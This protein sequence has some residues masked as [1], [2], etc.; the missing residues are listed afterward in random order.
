MSNYVRYNGESLN[1]PSPKLFG[2]MSKVLH[3]EIMGRCIVVY[4]HFGSLGQLSAGTAGVS[5]SGKYASYVNTGV[6]I[7][8]YS[9]VADIGTG[10]TG[11]LGVLEIAGND[12]DNDQGFVQ[13]G[14]GAGAFRIDNAS[15]NTGKVAFEAR[16]L[17]ESIAN[18]GVAFFL[19]L[20]TGPLAD[21]DLV[22]DTGAL[23]AG[24]GYIG[25]RRLCDDGDQMDIVYQAASQTG[26]EVLANAK[27]LVANTWYTVGFV[28]DPR[29]VD[30]KKIVFY[31][32][33]DAVANTVTT[34]N[35]DTATFPEGEAL[36]P[37]FLTK[38]GTAAEAKMRLDYVAAVQYAN[39]VE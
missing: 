11:A 23:A 25:F 13:F 39:G 7:A 26:V 36:S 18:D 14:S 32:D 29:E 16:F 22:D 5:L 1:S 27:T 20:G 21:A 15:G 8:G 6:T 37:L 4:D 19:G 30:S 17:T 34:T 28:Y 38:T 33:G 2:D 10:S 31:I 24:K 12:A 9:G 35:I 3:D